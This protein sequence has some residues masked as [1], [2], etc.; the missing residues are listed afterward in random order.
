MPSW[1][2]TINC[3]DAFLKLILGWGSIELMWL[4]LERLN[5]K[6]RIPSILYPILDIKDYKPHR[7]MALMRVRMNA[8]PVVFA[9]ACGQ[10]DFW[11]GK[12]AAAAVVEFQRAQSL[13]STDRNASIDIFHS[14]GKAAFKSFFKS[15]L[16]ALY[17]YFNASVCVVLRSH[18]PVLRCWLTV[19]CVSAAQNLPSSLSSD[20]I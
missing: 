17:D 10:R 16:F 20:H 8:L 9:S 7:A 18:E 13:I 14:I 1:L 11:I 4:Y 12:M 15:L 3:T 5:L 6:F 2:Y 19:L